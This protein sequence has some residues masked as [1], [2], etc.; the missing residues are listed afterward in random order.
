MY[1]IILI[2]YYKALIIINISLLKGLQ[3]LS[4]K[5]ALSSYLAS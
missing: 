4:K 5:W 2:L 3:S 1:K